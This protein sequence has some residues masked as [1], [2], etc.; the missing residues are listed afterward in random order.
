MRVLSSAALIWF[1]NLSAAQAHE[2][3]PAIADMTQNGDQLEFDVRLNLEGFVAGVDMSVATDTNESGQAASYDEL[4]AMEPEELEALFRAFWPQMAADISLVVDGDEMLMLVLMAV[5]VAP[6]GDV[7]VIRT[8]NIQFAVQLPAG[9]RS[10]EVG[11]AAKFGTLVLRQM[12]VD[13]PYTGYLEA[14]ARSEPIQLSGGDQAGLWQTFVGYVPVGFDHIVPKGLDHILFVLGLFFLST[15][16]RPLLTQISAF[17]VAHT[18]TLALAALG[19]VAVP[20]AIVEPLIAASIVF[21]AVENI[22]LHGIS[23]WRTVV[24]FG[25]GLLH[26]MGFA[27]VLGEFGLPQGAFVP[28][29]IGFNIGVELGQLAVVAVMFMCVVQAVRVDRGENEAT[30]AIWLYS[31]LVIVAAA[32]G[33]VFVVYPVFIAFV[34]PLVLV[35]VLCLA[36]VL[37]RDRIDAYRNIVSV[38]ISVAIAFIGAFWFVERVFL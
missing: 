22:F 5:E 26:G 37:L 29:L 3:L 34:L 33:F 6:I 28:A 4:R 12:G 24:V 9:A 36:S 35:F 8:S 2:I 1:T 23:R 30:R 11:W 10:I 32:G 25:F 13:A 31:L 17:T 27:S 7:E 38:P 19:Y 14:G 20:G 16:M 15:R 21:V 18:I